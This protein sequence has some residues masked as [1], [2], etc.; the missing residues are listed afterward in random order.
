MDAGDLVAAEAD[1]Q[2]AVEL[3]PSRDDESFSR[4]TAD[5]WSATGRL[6]E[7][8]GRLRDARDAYAIAAVQYAGSVGDGHPDTAR[9]RAAI[10][11]TSVVLATKNHN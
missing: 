7:T 5:A 10:S 2:L 6:R 8:Q 11:R 4:F 1:V 9:A 3:A